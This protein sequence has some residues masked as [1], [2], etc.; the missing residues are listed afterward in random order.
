MTSDYVVE[1]ELRI[2][3]W[4]LSLA[5][6]ISLLMP[7]GWL[8]GFNSTYVTKLI[9]GFNLEIGMHCLSFELLEEGLKINL[10]ST[11]TKTV[12]GREINLQTSK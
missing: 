1:V 2:S 4:S 6:E 11:V 12:I 9:V 5:T 7:W 8:V 3:P 10:T